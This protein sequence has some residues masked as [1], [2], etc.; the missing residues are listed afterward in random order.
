[1]GCNKV[2]FNSKPSA[3]LEIKRMKKSYNHKSKYLGSKSRPYLCPKCLNFHLTTMSVSAIRR[4]QY[5]K[6]QNRRLRIFRNIRD[7]GIDL[8]WQLQEEW[9]L[10]IIKDNEWILECDIAGKQHCVKYYK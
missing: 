5:I 3:K 2:V 10:L 9:M 4:S 6:E 8:L 1:M 7:G